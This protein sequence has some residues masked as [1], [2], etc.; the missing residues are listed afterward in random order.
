MNFGSQILSSIQPLPSE[1]IVPFS[2]SPSSVTV[3]IEECEETTSTAFEFGLF[4]SLQPLCPVR[5]ASTRQADAFSTLPRLVPLDHLLPV[6]VPAAGWFE[7][8]WR[9]ETE[10]ASREPSSHSLHCG[11][12]LE[13]GP[14]DRRPLR[15]L[16][17][18]CQEVRDLAGEQEYHRDPAPTTGNSP[19]RAKEPH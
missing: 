18:F 16:L 8:S 9:Q 15:I 13:G 19:H 11:R 2:S 1:E 6:S 7:D 14:S 10:K 5:C 3:P 12:R 17:I 4:L